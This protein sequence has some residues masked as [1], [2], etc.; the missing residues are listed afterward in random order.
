[1]NDF[2][3]ILLADD[4]PAG[5]ELTL[6]A[7]AESGLANEVAAVEDGE[8]ALD[9]LYR[10]GA[11]ARVPPGNPA[12]ILLDLKMPRVDGL[13]VLRQVRA[14]PQLCAIPVVVLTSSD[15]ES[16][17]VRSY[18]LGASAFVVKP[19]DIGAFIK[20][21]REVGLFWAVLNRPPPG[22]GAVEASR[23]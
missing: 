19:V 5:T 14:D 11:W 6:A 12:V 22:C 2:K 16:D 4:D 1:M 10:R 17:L 18:Q 7:L 20:A 3:R 15:Q 13:E 9:Y 8:Q 23:G 21:I